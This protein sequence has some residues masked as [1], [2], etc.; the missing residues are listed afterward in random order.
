MIKLKKARSTSSSE[1]TRSYLSCNPDSSHTTNV[2]QWYSRYINDSISNAH[3]KS[4]HHVKM[5]LNSPKESMKYYCQPQLSKM[6]SIFQQRIQSLFR[7]L[8][9]LECPHCT[10]YMDKSVTLTSKHMLTFYIARKAMRL[11]A[12]GKLNALG[13]GFD[14]SIRDLEIHGAGSLLGTEQSGMA[15]KVGFASYSKQ[16]LSMSW[17]WVDSG[18]SVSYCSAGCHCR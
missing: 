11:Q 16:R 4:H 9:P 13:S 12:I 17:N 18:K 8:G 1:R 7:T 2:T 3:E 14:V 15:A 6:E 5:W 10:S